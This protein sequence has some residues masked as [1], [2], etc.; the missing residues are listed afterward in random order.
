MY[1][2]IRKVFII[3]GADCKGCWQLSLSI[4]KSEFLIVKAAIYPKKGVNKIV[5]R[6]V[7]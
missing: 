4:F 3:M 7:L 1:G 2:S 5:L 6:F